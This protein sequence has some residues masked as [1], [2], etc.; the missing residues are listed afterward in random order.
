MN[1]NCKRL[2]AEIEN[3]RQKPIGSMT[4]EELGHLDGLVATLCRNLLGTMEAVA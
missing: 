4:P 3:A 2:V 1:D